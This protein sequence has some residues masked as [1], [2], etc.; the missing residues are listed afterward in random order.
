MTGLPSFIFEENGILFL[1]G[2]IILAKVK[3]VQTFSKSQ[4]NLHQISPLESTGYPFSD[5]IGLLSSLTTAGM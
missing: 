1:S 2:V 5:R 3:T 4:N